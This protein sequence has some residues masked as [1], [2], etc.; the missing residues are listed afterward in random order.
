[1]HRAI[2]PQIMAAGVLSIGAPTI[3]FSDIAIIPSED[4]NDDVVTED[5]NFSKPGDYIVGYGGGAGNLFNSN[6]VDI[7]GIGGLSFT[8]IH[9]FE[10]SS[11]ENG[12]FA[13]VFVPTTGTKTVTLDSRSSNNGIY[14]G[15]VGCWHVSG[16]DLNNTSS[17]IFSG[18]STFTA[19][20]TQGSGAIAFIMGRDT[21]ASVTGDINVVD[22]ALTS[23]PDNTAFY[24]GA[25]H[26][27]I[28][29][30]SASIT[31]NTDGTNTD[32]AFIAGV[33]LPPL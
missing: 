20:L 4:F 26:R 2:V 24:A 15:L 33:V 31:H 5:L 1:M 28:L 8:Q 16:Y 6:Q 17:L 7:T 22:Q 29:P 27:D 10:G 13:R 23:L 3:T 21:P 19:G 18:E 11:F 14:R 25:N 9:R 30:A 12:V 32:R